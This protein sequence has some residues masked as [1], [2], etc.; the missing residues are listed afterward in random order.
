[1]VTARDSKA[2]K[3]VILCGGMGIRAFPFTEY[4]PKPMLPINGSP[5][6][7]HIIRGFIAQGFSHFVLAA[8]YRKNVLDDYFEGKDLGAT[9][10]VVDTGEGADTG[11][12]IRACRHLVGDT[13]IAT[14]GDGLSDIPL[15]ALLAFHEEHAGLATVT[16]TP[17][18]TQYGV[19]EATEGGRVSR[20]IE[21]PTLREHWINIGFM[22]FRRC[23]FENW[24]G[25]NLERDVLPAL[26]SEGQLYMYRHE[27]FFKSLDSYK[28]QQ[29]FEELVRGG[30]TP[31]R[32]GS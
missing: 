31:W 23:V 4:L 3:V 26:A 18:F 30:R 17:L 5:I 11:A 22:V 10:E 1:M 15:D 12:R 16:V 32:V 24:K 6:L 19:L 21:K 29:D 13:F 8:G 2:I 25:D 27:G 7:V 20:M 28:D 14:Y 9:I